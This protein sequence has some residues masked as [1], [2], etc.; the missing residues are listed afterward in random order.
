MFWAWTA[1][2]IYMVVLGIGFLVRFHGGA[3]QSMRVIEPS[4]ADEEELLREAELAELLV[5][6]RVLSALALQKARGEG[7]A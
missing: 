1:G 4:L 7:I 5:E 3:W 2:T 6:K